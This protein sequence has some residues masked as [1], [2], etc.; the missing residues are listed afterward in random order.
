MHSAKL[1]CLAVLFAISAG[2][3]VAPVAPPTPETMG[4][5]PHHGQALRAPGGQDAG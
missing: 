3:A 4:P 5:Y 1:A 2:C